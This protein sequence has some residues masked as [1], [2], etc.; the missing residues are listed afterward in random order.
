MAVK[1]TKIL[2]H[3]CQHKMFQCAR[4]GGAN[5]LKIKVKKAD[6]IIPWDSRPGARWGRGR[7]SGSRENTCSFQPTKNIHEN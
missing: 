4:G 5:G 7:R 6:C 3:I 2:S 1:S